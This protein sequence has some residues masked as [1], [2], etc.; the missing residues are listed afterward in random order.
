ML[1]HSVSEGIAWIE[2]PG[3]QSWG[4]A[5]YC[6]VIWLRWRLEGDTGLKRECIT[7]QT[8][9]YLAPSAARHSVHSDLSSTSPTKTTNLPLLLGEIWIEILIYVSM[10]PHKYSAFP[11]TFQCNSYFSYMAARMLG[12]KRL[13]ELGCKKQHMLPRLC[14]YISDIHQGKGQQWCSCQCSSASQHQGEPK[15][16]GIYS[17]H[18]YPL[19]VVTE[20]QTQS[21]S[22]AQVIAA[23]LLCHVRGKAEAVCGSDPFPSGSSA[24]EQPGSPWWGFPS[25]WSS[26]SRDTCIVGLVSAPPPSSTPVSGA[27]LGSLHSGAGLGSGINPLRSVEI[28]LCS[29]AD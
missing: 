3:G 4:N 14:T 25:Y 19:S 13:P 29:Y 2:D 26:R 15:S 22:R 9:H 5:S 16:T 24:A 20:S 28:T 10:D 23:A 8:Q 18:L 27:T 11:G 12:P 21:T 7:E 1:Y 17:N 6:V